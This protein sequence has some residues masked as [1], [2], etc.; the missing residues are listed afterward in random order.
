MKQE[1]PIV[2]TGMK[3]TGKSTIGTLLATE[4]HCTFFDTDVVMTE[5][6]EIG[7]AHV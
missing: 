2:L 1:Y 5:I 7:R 3:H 4:L 6:A